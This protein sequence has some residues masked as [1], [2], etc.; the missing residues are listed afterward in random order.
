MQHE[1]AIR[2]QP[3]ISFL[4]SS[5]RVFQNIVWDVVDYHLTVN[6]GTDSSDVSVG[7]RGTHRTDL[8]SQSYVNWRKHGLCID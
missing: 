3:N 5:Q 7:I 8:L 1:V 6:C 4:R 2:F